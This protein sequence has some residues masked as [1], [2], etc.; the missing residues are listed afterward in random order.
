MKK[1][2]LIFLIVS[3]FL[4]V[5]T[6]CQIRPGD[7]PREGEITVF[8]NG[9]I[10]YSIVTEAG[11]SDEVK[12]LAKALADL[13]GASPEVLTDAAAETELELL[14]GS[15]TR[16][17]SSE[18]TDKL[19]D[20][21]TAIAIQ[22]VVA[23]SDE[24]LVILA[25]N[26]IGYIYAL[27][28]I[29]ETYISDG[30]LSVP[31]GT[32]DLK[33]VV[34]DDYFASELYLDRLTASA[35]K[36]RF[37]DIKDQLEN[38]SNRYDDKGNGIMTVQEAIE[39]YKK[40]VASFNT[41]DFGE[42]TADIFESANIYRAPT[43]YPE[44][45][46]H[47]RILLTADNI[48]SVRGNLSAD[49]SSAA[50]K[51][52]IALSDA[53][54]D[55]K[56]EPITGAMTTNYD[57]GMVGQIEAKALR[58]AL[59]R[60]KEKYPNAEDDPAA[61]YGYEAI[62]AVKN[63][64]LTLSI[65]LSVSD[66]CRLPGHLLYVM[67]C[68]YDWCY[69]LLTDE[70]KAQLIAGG[71]NILGKAQECVRY[72]GEYNKVPT[73]QEMVFGHGA[74]D[75]LAVDYF[76]F[77]I[78]CADEAP[79]IYELV[80]GRVLNDFVE[81]QSFFY[82]AGIHWQGTWYN[83]YR[84]HPALMVNILVNRM[85]GGE[86]TPIPN[87]EEAIVNSLHTIRPDGQI[88]RIGDYYHRENEQHYD[89]NVMGAVTAY[90]G[91]FYANERLK[92][93]GYEQRNE[94]S[95][96]TYQTTGL[97][98][99]QFLVTNDPEVSHTY[100]GYAPLTVTT[101]YP[102]T[103]LFAQSANDDPNAF[104]IYMSMKD[105]GIDTHSHMDTG[106][107]QI[108]YKGAL[109]TDSGAYAGWGSEH[110]HGYTVQSIASNSLL[111]YN[112]D[113]ANT[114]DDYRTNM[115]YSGGQSISNYTR[116]PQDLSE[117]LEHPR[118]AQVEHLGTANVEKDG[119]YLYSYMGGDMT[120]AYDKETVDEVTRYMFSV[121]TGDKD[122]PLV[123]ITF[124]RITSDKESYHK[125]AL[126][127]TQEA[128]TITEDG[129]AIITNTKNGNSGKLVVQ[130]VGFDTEY[131]VWGGEGREFWIPGVDENGNYSLEDGKNLPPS[132]QPSDI[133]EYGWGRI[134]ISPAEA[135][136]TNHMLT[137]MYVTDAGNGSSPVKAKDI[138][139]ENL[140]G[141][142][143]FGKAVLFSKNEK[144]L[145]E[146]SSFTLDEKADC[147]IAGVSAGEWTIKSGD[148]VVDTVTVAEGTN[149]ITFTA[150]QAGTYTITPAN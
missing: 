144:L 30:K 100:V 76:S 122:C 64:M 7:A 140:A 81:S 135:A 95:Y 25:D 138:G 11:A 53:P 45:G 145:T 66:A 41:S 92:A 102:Y 103:S 34:W 134:E 63:A 117:I 114:R 2:S 60:N 51:R 149:L 115:I 72:D 16:D 106:S 133:S 42:Y 20:S 13:S 96:F 59:E 73:A 55:G 3:V 22:F 87:V 19:K 146:E 104:Q 6:S 5:L 58:Y 29:K 18:L 150:T 148:T 24:K 17:A 83:S 109:S 69:D 128:P 131:T 79:E 4:I 123:F 142:L 125:A 121:A 139:S 132:R 31:R 48:E 54:C 94:F 78:A 118:I 8:D 124:D 112:P 65:D 136:K 143:I 120:G 14:I 97:S 75:Q 99:V 86:L 52:Y 71:V 126:I 57:A 141:S 40:M 80:G 74:E 77:A 88:L 15:T 119:N 130:S 110:H 84:T 50:Y 1:K 35:D 9:Q 32:Y 27:E 10:G 105:F 28:Y 38:E 127:H 21:A 107:F 98:P 111:I 36:D 23:E 116:F 67:A 39:K 49:E 44:N 61:A 90:A 82:Q 85:T 93:F 33:Y 12:E 137:V 46:Q 37:E 43:V 89:W 101:R 113:L 91:N 147:Y 62:Y 56:F 70:D 108:F 26:D 47:P 68:V 129:F